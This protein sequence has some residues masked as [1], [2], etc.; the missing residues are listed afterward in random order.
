MNFNIYAWVKTVSY[1]DIL[2]TQIESPNGV[3]WYDGVHWAIDIDT[4]KK[5]K[6]E[7]V[8]FNK[9]I[10]TPSWLPD[11]WNASRFIGWNRWGQ[12]VV[13]NSND[14]ARYVRRGLRIWQP[15]NRENKDLSADVLYLD[16]DEDWIS[17]IIGWKRLNIFEDASSCLLWLTAMGYD[18]ELAKKHINSI[19]RS[20]IN[21]YEC[22]NKPIK[23]IPYE[24][25]SK[26]PHASFV[27][28]SLGKA[29]QRSLSNWEKA[30][31]LT[32][33]D[34]F[35]FDSINT[36]IDC[37]TGEQVD[38]IGLA[39]TAIKN[40]SSFLLGDQ[41]GLG[42]GRVLAAIAI[43]AQNNGLIPIFFTEKPT[44]FHDFWRDIEDVSGN[45]N[46]FENT[47]ILH[48][49]QKLTYPNGDAWKNGFNSKSRLEILN[50]GHIPD[51]VN[52]ILT[53]YSQFNR[54]NKSKIKLLKNIGTKAVYLFDE[55]HNATGQSNIRE[56]I[57]ILRNSSDGCVY[58]SA[59]FGKDA[60]HVTF[61]TE[62]LGKSL[63]LHDWGLWLNR[64]DA[65]PLRVSVSRRLVKAGRMV[66]REQDLSG[67]VYTPRL[68]PEDQMLGIS[69]VADNFSKFYTGLLHLQGMLANNFP[70]NLKHKVDPQRL[71]GGKLYRLNRLMF[72]VLLIKHVTNT[73]NT[74]IKSGVKPVI[75]CETTLEQALTD[76]EECSINN[77]WDSLADVLVSEIRILVDGWVIDNS[78]Q[79]KE[80]LEKQEKFENWVRSK[81]SLLPPSPID[82]VR[83]ELTNHNIKVGEISGRKQRLVFKNNS[84]FPE[85]IKQN[86]V[87]TVRDFNSGDIDALIVTRAGCSGISLHASK[88]FKDQRP[89]E[90]VEWQTPSN[91]AERVQFFGRVYRK[92]QVVPSG[93]STLV[94]NLPSE[95]RNQ[96]WQYRKMKKLFQFTV[97][98]EQFL[99]SGGNLDDYLNRAQADVWA[100]LWL[101]HYPKWAF[102]LGISG[103]IRRQI[104]W[105]DRIFSRLPLLKI[106]RQKVLID[107]WDKAQNKLFPS[108]D[109][110][111]DLTFIKS[112]K[113]NGGLELEGYLTSVEPI[114]KDES[115]DES[116]HSKLMRKLIK[117]NPEYKDF[118]YKLLNISIGDSVIWMNPDKRKTITGRI[119]GLWEPPEPFDDFWPAISLHLWSPELN[120]SIWL[121][122][123]NLLHDKKFYIR[124]RSFSIDTA[125][126]AYQEQQRVVWALKGEP[127]YLM[128]WKTHQKIGDWNFDDPHRLWLPCF[129]TPERVNSLT[130][131]IG[132][133]ISVFKYIKYRRQHDNKLVAYDN[134]GYEMNLSFTDNDNY[135]LTWTDG[136]KL[137]DGDIVS[138][139]FR[140]K[141][142]NPIKLSDGKMA[143]LCQAKSCL[144]MIFHLMGR[145]VIFGVPQSEEHIISKIEK[146]FYGE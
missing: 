7:I 93:V 44:L 91:V 145:G 59:T 60:E 101:R 75:I 116:K 136:A 36:S 117:E 120:K 121:P 57:R 114:P 13:E 65:E 5:S 100:N 53:T 84:W 132:Q 131:P 1:H 98:Q 134:L 68:V 6:L 110:K 27:P 69:E 35:V 52:M 79:A 94:M 76:E 85:K 80:V 47:L 49:N 14:G 32:K 8:G 130:I 64:N 119:I 20:E 142:G 67:L 123:L 127:E 38:A 30:N 133:P 12:P 39:I 87:K 89:R 97:G 31:P 115:F 146:D 144:S 18:G 118:F 86:R 72:L 58:S 82:A 99:E 140:Q 104:N 46:P 96:I 126:V 71:F 143:V 15:F 23:Q 45:E 112:F 135:T 108:C 102:L 2:H 42:K 21:T 19:F 51:N 83:L 10:A 106:E 113:I 122:M 128:L 17:T 29:T 70:I 138:I 81:F 50:S 73:S 78:M 77:S 111:K 61:Y 41:T 129:L 11:E 139:V 3:A 33:M 103:N 54:N 107:F 88:R 40:N 28:F 56:S 92:D 66:R 16:T 125:S 141:Y 137:D 105:M 43:W 4:W 109:D 63:F 26:Q 34:S 25:L 24:P 9:E 37:F 22:I 95:R 124:N 55:A 62:L 90:I 48:Q 74:L